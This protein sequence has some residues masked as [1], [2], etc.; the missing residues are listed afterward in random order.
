ML[1]GVLR[2]DWTGETRVAATPNTVARLRKLGYEVIVEPVAGAAA[3]FPDAACADEDPALGEGTAADV[4]LGVNAPAGAQL[5]R[6]ADGAT[7]IAILTPRLG[8]ALV[9]DIAW[10][11][12][13]R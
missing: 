9:A 11:L 12:H 13:V 2:E 8:D 1:I 5:D 6:L 4:V 7:V 3:G 10:R